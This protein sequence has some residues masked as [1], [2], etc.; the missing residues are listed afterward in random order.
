MIEVN[1]ER[2]LDLKNLHGEV[3]RQIEKSEE[4]GTYLI[5]NY[6]RIKRLPFC[7]GAYH[8]PEMI[9]RQH[10]SK[11]NG[12]YKLK[13]G[14]K[15]RLVHRLVAMAFVPKMWFD[16]QVDHRNNIKTD[17]RARNLKWATAKENAN[18]P[19]TLWERH[20]ANGTAKGERPVAKRTQINLSHY[21][22]IINLSKGI[23][24]PFPEHPYL[25][26]IKVGCFVL[27]Y[28]DRVGDFI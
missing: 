21:N 5:S 18:N 3:W 1:S 12:Y 16:T 15:L 11:K 23:F 9:F 24:I 13:V 8:Y 28:D 4:Y 25:A 19:V 2:W 10:L 14:G 27:T 6:G 26:T 17:N 20:N 7:G 22:P